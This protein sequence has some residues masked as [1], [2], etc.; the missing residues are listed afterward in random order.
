ME[1]NDFNRCIHNKVKQF[2]FDLQIKKQQIYAREADESI[3]NYHWEK[4]KFYFI[5]QFCDECINKKIPLY[6]RSQK[7]EKLLEDAI[8]IIDE[9]VQKYFIDNQDQFVYSDKKSLWE[10]YELMCHTLL[11]LNN[12][13]V[14]LTKA[15][16]DYGVDIVASKEGKK[17][18]IQCKKHKNTVGIKAIQEVFSGKEYYKCTH[19]V[20]CSNVGYSKNAK[21][22][23]ARLGVLLIHHDYLKILDKLLMENTESFAFLTKQDDLVR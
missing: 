22:L 4:E 1:P 8:L 9:S 17:V 16:P 5:F 11:R 3:G 2:A 13:D 12:W 23:G 6:D 19:A 7:Q 18:A 20:V 14:I 15:G 10:E 21:H